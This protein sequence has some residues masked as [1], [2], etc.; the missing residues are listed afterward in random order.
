VL[1]V[2]PYRQCCPS[3]VV[4]AEVARNLESGLAITDYSRA[5]KF[6]TPRFQTDRLHNIPAFRV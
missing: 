1:Q 5:G 3:V 6:H 4:A 2:L